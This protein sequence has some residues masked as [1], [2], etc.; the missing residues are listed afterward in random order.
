MWILPNT[1]PLYSAFAPECLDSKE[2]LKQHAESLIGC[3]QKP[4]LMWKSK[5][6]SFGTW[7][8]KWN[9]VYWLQHLFTRTL[10]PSTENHFVTKYTASLGDIHANH[11][12][13]LEKE[14]E[15][16]TLDTFGRLYHE[17]SKQLSLFSASLKT[18]PDTSHWDMAKFTEAYEIWVTQ[19]RQESTQRRKLALHT[20]ESDYSSSQLKKNW[21]TATVSDIHSANLKSSQQKEGS[22]YSVTL[23]QAISM[24]WPTPRCSEWKGVGEMGSKSHKHME[25]KQYLCAIVE[26]I[27]GR[28]NQD[29]TNTNG[30]RP[31]LNPAWVLQLMGTTLEKT[32]CDWQEM[33]LYRKPH[34]ELSQT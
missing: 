8:S 27:D 23:A 15:Q 5:P 21:P 28:P 6:L 31:V 32:F 4:Q 34:A 10:K 17:L 3:N 1:L 11:S 25:E 7:L 18:L 20:K 14:K 12:A 19:L 16:K 26:L 9:R 13:L 30:K 24:K 29:K 2:D 33:A 22:M